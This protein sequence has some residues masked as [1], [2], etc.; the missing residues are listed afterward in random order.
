MNLEYQNRIGYKYIFLL[1]GILFCFNLFYRYTPPENEEEKYSQIKSY[2]HPLKNS[3]FSFLFNELQNKR[4]VVLG[5]QLHQD[6]KT[7]LMKEKIIRYLHENMDY[8][9]VLYEAGLYD[10]W[11]MASN[12]DYLNP[13]TGLYPFWWN[14]E[15]TKGIW[16]YYRSENQQGDSIC[17]GGFDIQLTGNI[18]DS[19]RVTQ[20]MEY[21]DR[22]K[23][24][25][26]PFSHLFL[27]LEKG[28]RYLS[29]KN[30]MNT[31]FTKEQRDSILME[32]DSITLHIQ[33]INKPVLEDKIFY[34]Y[35]SGLKQ[36]F[37]SVALYPEVGNPQ[38]MQIRDSLMADNLIWL[39][40]SVYPDKKIM[41]GQR[42]FMPFI[43]M[44]PRI[45]FRG[46]QPVST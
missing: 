33:R 30:G 23:I 13:E 45:I 5:E 25:S 16:D 27:F 21:L 1:L 44:I 26:N 18:A 41:Y 40:D 14:S 28:Q 31:Q 12:T 43:R 42:I 15:E 8:D 34:R 22:K 11:L 7:F 10:M 2:L 35:L 39:A 32:L 38:R 36:R 19:T 20:I 6:G 9:V 37:E 4:I 24:W 46:K 29:W 17:L 3:D